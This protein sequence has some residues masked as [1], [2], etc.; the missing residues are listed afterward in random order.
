MDDSA[1]K[2]LNRL[3]FEN[4]MMRHLLGEAVSLMSQFDRHL[5]MRQHEAWG[6]DQVG[7]LIGR[8]ND[9]LDAGDQP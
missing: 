2:Q 9:A 8:I 1:M 5:T 4:G 6:M 7:D 3:A